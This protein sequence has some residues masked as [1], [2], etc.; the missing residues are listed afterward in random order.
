MFSLTDICVVVHNAEWR[1]VTASFFV[2][3]GGGEGAQ[4]CI[5]QVF[6]IMYCYS[7]D[8]VK[9]KCKK[10]NELIKGEKWNLYD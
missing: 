4:V 6:V 2:G 7:C 5:A 3:G 8:S 9:I 1:T 10:K